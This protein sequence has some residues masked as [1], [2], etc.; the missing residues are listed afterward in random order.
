MSNYEAMRQQHMARA[1]ALA[2]RLIDRLDWP[3]DRLA[4]YRQE[5]LRDL[6]RTAT[7]RSPWYASRLAGLDIERLDETTLAE[8]PVLTKAE[9]M[10]HFDDIVTDRRLSL[11]QLEQHLRTVETGSYLFGRYTAITSGGSTGQRGVFVYD[12][13]SWAVAWLSLFRGVLRVKMADPELATRPAVLASV[14]AAHFSHG[15]AALARTFRSP[16]MTTVRLPVTLPTEE[17][18]A[19]LNRAQPDFMLV[20]PSVLYVLAREAMAGRLRI[21]PLRVLAGAEPLLPEI[22]AAAEQAWDI[23]VI[24]VWGTSEGGGTAVGCDYGGTHISED[25]LIVEPVDLAG[26]PVAPGERSAKVYLTNLYNAAL[27]LIRYEITDEVTVLPGPCPCG[28]AH[29]HIADV[30][31]RLDDVFV[32][33]GIHIHPHLF[34]SELGREAAVVEYQVRQTPAG[35]AIAVHC[36]APVTLDGLRERIA[37]ALGRAGLERPQVTIETVDRFERPGGPAKLKR[38]IPLA[39]DSEPSLQAPAATKPVAVVGAGR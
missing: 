24:N 37:A 26:W 13:D 2:P 18:V 9:L 25:E 29:R 17:I 14:T 28:S 6:V 34:R 11:A 35:A 33:Q 16:K 5:R 4:A 7:E 12:W 39:A 30:Q 38:F 10:E 31:G 1:L 32:Y 23:K 27:P 22:R 21:A 15:T 36:T 19:G 20:Y 8:L 3:A